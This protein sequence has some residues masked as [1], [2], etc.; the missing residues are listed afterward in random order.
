M[1]FILCICILEMYFID[2]FIIQKP[3]QRACNDILRLSLLLFQNC[4]II[5]FSIVDWFIF[6]LL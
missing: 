1:Y 3:K 4:L 6:L 2:L 5:F